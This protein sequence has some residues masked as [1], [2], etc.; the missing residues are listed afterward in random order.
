MILTDG[1]D[2]DLFWVYEERPSPGG[3]LAQDRDETF[4]GAEDRAVDNY[5]ASET[6]FVRHV[7][8]VLS[9]FSVL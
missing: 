4:Q 2:Y 7:V 9:V 5:G 1:Y 8:L 3:V 6:G